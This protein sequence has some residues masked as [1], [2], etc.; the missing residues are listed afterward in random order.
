MPKKIK[1]C[2]NLDEAAIAEISTRCKTSR[3]SFSAELEFAVLE[4]RFMIQGGT[5]QIIT[6]SE[7]SNGGTPS[8]IAASGLN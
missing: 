3:R 4:Y 1:K 6:A 2:V 7:V 5:H 8:E